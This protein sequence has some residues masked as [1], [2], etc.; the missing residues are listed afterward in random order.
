VGGDGGGGS[1]GAYGGDDDDGGS[2]GDGW[3]VTLSLWQLG[4]GGRDP[5]LVSSWGAPAAP[6]AAAAVVGFALSAFTAPPRRWGAA[7]CPSGAHVALTTHGHRCGAGAALC[8]AD[9]GAGRPV[10]ASYLCPLLAQPSACLAH[11]GGRPCRAATLAAVN[12]P[13]DAGPHPHH[14][15]LFV[16]LSDG[17]LA[18]AHAAWEGCALSELPPASS[19]LGPRPVPLGPGAAASAAWWG[20]R[21]LAVA[22]PS[23]S[24]AVAAL[25]GARN[26]LGD[27]PAALAPGC[28]VAVCER[29]GGP[30]ARGLLVLEPWCVS[31]GGGAGGSRGSPLLPDHPAGGGGGGGGVTGWLAARLGVGEEFAGLKVEAREA[32]RRRSSGGGGGA[33]RARGGA[34]AEAPACWRLSVLAERTAPEMVQA[35][36]RERDWGRAMVLARAAGVH[37]DVVYKGR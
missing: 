13:R 36:L 7:A 12:M 31:A 18:D 34:A 25:P 24:V 21:R 27:A 6:G 15:C 23:G 22:S 5:E 2:G 29:W 30:G 10:R 28:R 37:P 9:H 1:D 19:L 26:M 33:A 8:P 11:E 35:H 17:R 16:S 4:P 3:N 14:S 32:R 20:P